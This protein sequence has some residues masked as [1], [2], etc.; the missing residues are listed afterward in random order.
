MKKYL[1]MWAFLMKYANFV[2]EIGII[3][4]KLEIL[5]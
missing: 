5:R 4:K 2:V 1:D 3:C